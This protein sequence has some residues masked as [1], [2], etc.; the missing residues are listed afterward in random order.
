MATKDKIMKEY[1][2]FELLNGRAPHSVFELTK[3]LKIEESEF[4]KQFANLDSIRQEILKD[5]INKTVSILDV[6]PDY[7]GYSTREQLLA[8]YYTLFEQMKAKRSYLLTKYKDI[9]RTAEHGKDWKP[10]L[11]VLV[12]RASDIMRTGR[13]AEE[14]KDRPLVGNHYGKGAPI[15][16][17]YIFRVWVNDASEDFADTDAAIEK[18]VNTGLDLLSGSPFDSLFDFGK[19]AF[20]TKLF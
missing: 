4:Y 8:L 2:E 13:D 20:K 6:D 19:F 9:I 7:H 15:V 16:F 1:M 3:K 12:E 5:L 11:S 14:V 18:S 10:F 17:F